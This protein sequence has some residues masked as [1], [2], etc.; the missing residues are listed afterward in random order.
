MESVLATLTAGEA[1]TRRWDVVVIGAGPAGAAAAI[2]A[3]RAGAG[4]LL[5]DKAPFPR[6]KVCG[7]CLSGA[8]L[9]TLAGMGLGDLPGRCGARSLGAIRLRAF[10]RVAEMAMPDGAAVSRSVLDA[11]LVGAAIEAGAAF[12]PGTGAEAGDLEADHRHVHLRRE[13]G[14]AGIEA[15]MVIDAGGLRSGIVEREVEDGQRNDSAL[16][17]AGDRDASSG[18][19]ARRARLGINWRGNC[20]A[21]CPMGVSARLDAAAVGRGVIDMAVGRGGYVGMVRLEDD[22][23]DVAGAIDPRFIRRCGDVGA[24]VGAIV[25]EAGGSLPSAVDKARWHGTGL[26][27]WRPRRVAAPRLLAVGDAGGY[28]EPF[29]GEGIGWAL[30]TG[31]A[32]GQ[33]AAEQA[34]ADRPAGHAGSVVRPGRWS[35]GAAGPN[36]AAHRGHAWLIRR[37][38]DEHRRLV[39]ESQRRCRWIARLLRRPMLVGGLVRLLAARPGLSRPIMQGIHQPGPLDTAPPPP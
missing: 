24:A 14:G 13:S 9:S 16:E 17:R 34:R 23:V 10:G 5:I 39:G 32:A 35:R 37:W 36:V 6:E 31:W 8:A 33:L 11:A 19:R 20:G 27:T 29:T 25:E 21:R 28:V 26:L 15:A 4:T 22:S 12:L 30:R 18:R 38:T 1:A 2:A 7:C 3:A